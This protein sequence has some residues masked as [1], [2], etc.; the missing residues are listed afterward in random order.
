MSA[1]ADQVRR[2]NEIEESGAE[3]LVRGTS[4]R[5]ANSRKPAVTKG[6]GTRPAVGLGVGVHNFIELIPGTDFP[7]WP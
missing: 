2:A 7:P 4:K 5:T 6:G 3:T 1:A